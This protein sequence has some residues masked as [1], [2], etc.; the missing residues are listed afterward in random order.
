MSRNPYD[1]INEEEK[2]DT[3]DETQQRNPYD[4]INQEEPQLNTDNASI[5]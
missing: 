2:Q 4:L 5:S 3:K 1:L